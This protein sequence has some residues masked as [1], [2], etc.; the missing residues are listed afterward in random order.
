MRS[1][2]APVSATITARM[3]EATPITRFLARHPDQ[4]LRRIQGAFPRFTHLAITGTHSEL[5]S[6]FVELR[7]AL[8]RGRTRIPQVYTSVAEGY[9]M[10]LFEDGVY[11]VWSTDSECPMLHISPRTRVY[12]ED[13]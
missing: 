7:H 1:P 13:L 3:F 2:F 10:S 12:G 11:Y 4:T 8:S 9:S 5:A 6:L